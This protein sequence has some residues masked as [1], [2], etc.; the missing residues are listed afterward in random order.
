MK[1]WLHL[2]AEGLAAPSG[3]W[4]CCLWRAAGDNQ[5]MLLVEAAQSL[6]AQPVDVLLPMEMCSFV[7]SEPWPSKRRPDAQ[8]IA[9]AI[10]EQL[11]EDLE[12][13]HVCAGRRDRQGRYPVLVT[14]K[15][16]LRALLQL[17]A[18]LGIEVSSV[19]VDANVL[20]NGTLA[21]VDWYDRR[22]VGGDLHL[23]LSSQG[24]K[25]LEPLLA[26]P[27]QWLDE[28]DSLALIEQALWNG[29]GQSID[30]LQGE[31]ARPRRAWPWASLVLAVALLFTL[32]WGF[33]LVRIQTLE[34]QAHQ[35]YAQS[36]QRFQALYPQQTRV[37][38]L[39]AQLDA[40][41]RQAAM[42]SATAL[43]RLVRL[44]EQVIGGGDVDVQRIDFR[45][46]DGWKVQLT[47]ASFNELEQ[48]RERGQQNGMP[49][50]IGNSSKDGNRV[51]AVLM[52]E[53]PR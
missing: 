16:R 12:V 40:L 25:A 22:V 38:D 2:S 48:L 23:A 44:T 30:L 10:E 19:Q 11:G 47:T 36:L 34:G 9:F 7:R 4:P 39:S 29:H 53:E 43:A 45:A 51:Q 28:T 8:A 1:T 6:G 50:R 13:V 35:L 49:V 42:P 20:P 5:R 14:H 24:L 33:K 37:I 27:L 31:F 15:A 52:L 18:A 41:H 21:A 32:D 26:E 17:L 3:Q 46:G